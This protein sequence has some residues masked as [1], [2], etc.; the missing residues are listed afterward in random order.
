[1]SSLLSLLLLLLSLLSLLLLSLLLLLFSWLSLFFIIFIIIIIIISIIIIIVIIIS[2]IITLHD[3]EHEH[4]LRHPLSCLREYQH[5][6]RQVHALM[7]IDPFFHIRFTSFIPVEGAVS[8]GQHHDRR[9]AAVPSL[10]PKPKP[11]IPFIAA[12]QSRHRSAG[13]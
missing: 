13:A 3:N 12:P 6:E 1:L 5:W 2:I 8:Q 7:V 4:H 11:N 9:H 10:H